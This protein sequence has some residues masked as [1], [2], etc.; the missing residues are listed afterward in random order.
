MAKITMKKLPTLAPGD[1]VEIIAPAS[2]FSETRLHGLK[3][4][5]RSWQLNYIIADDILGDDLLCANSD[6]VRFKHLK[7]ALYNPK[8]KAVIC[9]S[10][11]YGSMRLIPEL[12]KL[13][14]P[15]FCKIFIGMS[16]ATALHLYLQQQWQWP[17]IHAALAPDKF[18]PK[19][20][21]TLKSILVGDVNHIQ[22]T[23]SPLNSL[24]EIESVIET[25]ITGGN[26]TLIQAGV[27]THWQI[28]GRDKIMLVEET[29][30]RGYRIDRMLEH[31]TQTNI[32]KNTAA[33]I[34]GDFIG[35]GEPNGSDL[36]KLVLQ[37]FAQHCKIP[38]VHIE[39]I[40][41]G[42]TNFP[43][44]LGTPAKLRFGKKIK[45]I[46]NRN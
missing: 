16:D 46:C 45:L 29:G 21:D 40:G 2:R 10:G 33:I 7:N 17:T 32:F 28:D 18:S 38:V 13:A 43:V 26:M 44:P 11:G 6:D 25:T 27:G 20:L 19:C 34:F 36:T 30:E 12:T 23:G 39:G 22:F 1:F 15:P 37:R 24:A 41:H 35:G 5:L 3:D 4:L 9:A 42:F 8:T 31:F 14:P